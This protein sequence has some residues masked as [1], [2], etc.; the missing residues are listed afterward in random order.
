[1]AQVANKN[2]ALHILN[3]QAMYHYYMENDFLKG[4][5]MVSFNE[6]MCYGGTCEDLFSQEF[7]QIRAKV[8]RVTADQYKEHTLKPLRPFFDKEFTDI[9][10]WFDADMFCQINLLTIL[11]WLDR[12]DYKDAIDVHIVG[13]RF[14]PV[15][16]YRVKAKGY[17]AVYKQ[18]LIQKTIPEY[19]ELAPLKKGIELYVNYLHED[20]GLMVYIQEHQDIPETELVLALIKK[21][22]ASY[23]L[24]DTQY[25]EIIKNHRETK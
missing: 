12:A 21:F 19:I 1:M 5:R 16:L 23:G 6:A 10:L 13:D 20:S 17:E 2:K 24:G 9:A 4:E 3:G 11:A 8:H 15:S 14:E 25:L 18:V 7:I 22:A